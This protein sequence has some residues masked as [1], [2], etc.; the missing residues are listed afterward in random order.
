MGFFGNLKKETYINQLAS[1]FKLLYDC[2]DMAA[3]EC[4]RKNYSANELKIILNELKEI[5]G[6]KVITRFELEQS[7][8]FKENYDE[9]AEIDRRHSGN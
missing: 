8:P 3:I 9:V 4:M 1:S 5:A 6:G 2:G 7:S